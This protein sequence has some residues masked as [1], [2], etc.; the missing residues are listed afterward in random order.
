MNEHVYGLQEPD[1]AG[2]SKGGA[3]GCRR[4]R[5]VGEVWGRLLG[6][7]AHAVGG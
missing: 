2:A 6:E 1:A 3:W 4:R 5:M 7:A